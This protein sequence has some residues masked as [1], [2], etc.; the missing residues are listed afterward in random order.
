LQNSAVSLS[1]AHARRDTSADRGAQPDVSVVIPAYNRLWA[2]P[3]AVE[4][5]RNSRCRTKIIVVDDGSTDGTWAWLQSQEDVVPIRTDHWG[6]CWAANAGFAASTGAYIRFLDSDDWLLD[7]ANDRQLD[8]ARSTRADVVLAGHIHL[9]EV[10]GKSEEVACLPVDDFLAQ[11]IELVSKGTDFH[12]GASLM[13]RQF[14]A[15]IPHRQEFPWDDIMFMIEV[16]LADPR[17]AV[18]NLPSLVYRQHDRDRR[19]SATTG[20][21]QL[22]EVWRTIAMYRK[23]QTL[24]RQ[25]GGCTRRRESAILAALWLEARKLAPWS[26][27]EATALA[28]YIRKQDDTFIPPVSS[29]LGQLYRMLGFATMERIAR[30]R[31]ALL[32]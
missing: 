29:A 28:A 14:V 6:K 4:S 5:C 16:G 20:F 15:D 31:R 8:I 22:Y 19:R 12:Y 32:G 10:S 30:V 27:D 21:N 26:I 11:Y 1:K 25:R 3:Q 23:A 24:L 18:C 9:D 7:G 13:R 2:L 17:L